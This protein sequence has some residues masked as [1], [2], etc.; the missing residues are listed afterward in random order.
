L[1][2]ETGADSPL[3]R[4]LVLRLDRRLDD[5]LSWLD[6]RLG[7]D[8]VWTVFTATQGLA[9]SPEVLESRGIPAGRVAGDKVVAAVEAR[10]AAAFGWGRYVER[11][12]FPSLYLR[13]Q[14]LDKQPEAPRLA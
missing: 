2:L 14:I 11:Y 4:D 13:Q 7:A 1:G 10:L 9:E 3:M 8:H 5:F 6:T 12:V